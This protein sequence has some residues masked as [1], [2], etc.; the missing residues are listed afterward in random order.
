MLNSDATL[1]PA[2][3]STTGR[4]VPLSDLRLDGAVPTH[5]DLRHDFTWLFSG[6]AHRPGAGLR[7]AV[8]SV[9][10]AA[11]TAQAPL[12]RLDAEAALTEGGAAP[13]IPACGFAGLA[14]L[15]AGLSGP[16][17][18]ISLRLDW[19]DG[20]REVRPLGT[21]EVVRGEAPARTPADRLVAVCMATYNPDPELFRAQ[22][23]SLVAQT[24]RNWI[25]LIQDDGSTEER[26]REIVAATAGDDRFQLDRNPANL[27]F[28]RNFERSLSRVPADAAFVAFSDQDDAWYPD[29]LR[30]L[31]EPLEAGAVL[32]FCD[33]RVVDR[34][35]GVLSEVF[36]PGR[37]GRHDQAGA[38]LMANVVTGCACLFRAELLDRALPFPQVK[39]YAYHDHWI[40]CCAA[41]AG[42]VAYVPEPLSDYVQHGGNT[43]GYRR[44]GIRLVAK[45]AAALVLSPLVA[46]AACVDGVR[47]RWAGVFRLLVDSARQEYLV[48][49]A[50]A[51]AL[52]R[53]G[54]L[55]DGADAFPLGRGE[56]RF[57]VR[58]GLI[59]GRRGIAYRVTALRLLAGLAVER[60]MIRLAG[61]TTSGSR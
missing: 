27:G 48:R 39:R 28:Y 40:A 46:A 37:Q 19:D 26:W 38:L 23:A 21:V 14:S 3:V 61:R 17:L 33:M 5:V 4:S 58:A 59:P 29:K 43:L 35:G 30:R 20:E 7:G 45:A 31:I 24:H 41:G 6:W 10:P 44:A 15:P 42:P 57:L 2:G 60:I 25:C 18:A 34:R 49:V 8:L 53:R 54:L 56:K 9:G 50:F 36:W 22:V 16:D 32:A 11:F 55:P 47:R 52:R 13:G 12:V 51:E 1:T